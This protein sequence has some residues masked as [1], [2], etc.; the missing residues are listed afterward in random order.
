M[1]DERWL[2]LHQAGYS[3]NSRIGKKGFTIIAVVIVPWLIVAAVV[4]A[5]LHSREIYRLF[6]ISG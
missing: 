5:V 3:R 2:T 4:F 1:A 6:M